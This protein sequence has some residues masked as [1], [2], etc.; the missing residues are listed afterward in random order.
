MQSAEEKAP[1]TRPTL[2]EV[3]RTRLEY[4]EP[5]LAHLPEAF[6]L[7]ATPTDTFHVLDPRPALRHAGRIADEA[8]FSIGDQSL[9]LSWYSK[10][11]SV[12]SVYTAAELHQLT[13]PNTAYTFLDTLLEKSATVSNSLDEV[14]LFSSYI[15]KS[16]RGII[17][18]SGIL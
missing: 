13:S 15:F 11:I 7:L 9:Q 1:G 5:V 14:S 8:C 3:L 16:W 6:A 10:R 4:N 18:S 2:K 17:K 12:A